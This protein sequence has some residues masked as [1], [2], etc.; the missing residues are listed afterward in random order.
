MRCRG[1][2]CAEQATRRS[3]NHVGAAALGCPAE[4]SSAR[5]G[6]GIGPTFRK[7]REKWGTHANHSLAFLE[8]KDFDRKV[9]GVKLELAKKSKMAADSHFCTTVTL[10]KPT[11]AESIPAGRAN[12]ESIPRLGYLGLRYFCTNS[13]RTKL[14]ISTPSR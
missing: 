9:C 13:S 5:S 7:E 10:C 4:H 12:R 11:V 3:R 6:M 2:C 1:K 14:G 8:V